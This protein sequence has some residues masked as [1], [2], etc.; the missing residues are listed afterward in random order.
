M[1]A[2]KPCKQMAK[3]VYRENCLRGKA[4]AKECSIVQFH[5]SMSFVHLFVLF[6]FPL[7]MSPDEFSRHLNVFLFRV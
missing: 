4:K 7:D 1:K 6:L 2:K 3:H 5:Q